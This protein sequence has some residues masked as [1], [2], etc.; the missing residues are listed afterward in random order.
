MQQSCLQQ[1][2]SK[3]ISALHLGPQTIPNS[4]RWGRQVSTVLQ[5]KIG[6]KKNSKVS[7]GRC[8]CHRK[9]EGVVSQE[10]LFW[11]L[12]EPPGKRQVVCPLLK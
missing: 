5:A 8:G 2:M 3:E 7:A 1:K 12:K 11:F 6:P 9:S 4:D 10:E